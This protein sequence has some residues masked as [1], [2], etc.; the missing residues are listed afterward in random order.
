MFRKQEGYCDLNM[1]NKEKMKGQKSKHEPVI[2]REYWFI[3][4][5]IG[6]TISGL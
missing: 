6:R 2:K 4:A 3:L 5:S 1:V